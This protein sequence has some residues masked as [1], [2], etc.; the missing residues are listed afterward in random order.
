MKKQIQPIDFKARC[1][2]EFIG[3][4]AQVARLLERKANEL[5][6]DK[7]GRAKVLLYGEPGIGK[8]DIAEMFALQLAGHATCIESVNG[9]NV[10]IELVRKWQ[11]ATRYLPIYGLFRVIIVNELETSGPEAQDLLLTFLDEMPDCTAFIATTNMELKQLT[12]RLQTRFQ[13][14]Q[15]KPPSEKE[16]TGLLSRWVKPQTAKEISFGCG[17]NVR[18]ALLDAQSI[19]DAKK[20]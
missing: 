19:L 20:I 10:R 13:Q 9:R 5:R 17:F 1:P 2:A 11:E 14:F 4:P 6:R 12:P 3:Q 18:A 8:T 7:N 15:I 16:I